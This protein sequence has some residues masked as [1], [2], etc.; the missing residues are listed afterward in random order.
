MDYR[1]CLVMG[2]AAAA[3]LLGVGS[4]GGTTAVQPADAEIGTN[5][6]GE[7]ELRAELFAELARIGVDPGK[8]A[9]SAP[10]GPGVGFYNVQIEQTES[11]IEPGD[12]ASVRMS[13][14]FRFPGDY[15]ANGEVNISDVTTLAQHLGETV[16]YL[17]LEDA[18]GYPWW[19]TQ[20]YREDELRRAYI[21]GDGNGEINS[22]DIIPIAQHFGQS[23]S[24]FYIYRRDPGSSEF[25]ELED[26][27]AR[28]PVPYPDS[29]Y[30]FDGAELQVE[31]L[32]TFRI[33]PW[34]GKTATA[35]VPLDFDLQ[36]NR[37]SVASFTVT[38]DS[39]TVPATLTL[40]ASASTDPDG[41]DFNYYYKYSYPGEEE[42]NPLKQTSNAIE[43]LTFTRAG[44]IRITLDLHEG[45]A[46]AHAEQTINLGMAG[47]RSSGWAFEEP[48]AG[49][50]SAGAS[51]IVELNGEP[52]IAWISSDAGPNFVFRSGGQ[53]SE[54]VTVSGRT[55]GQWG[56]VLDLRIIAARPALA[57]HRIFLPGSSEVIV[58]EDDTYLA[59]S[60]GHDFS[61]TMGAALVDLAGAPA[62]LLKGMPGKT[63]L[64]GAAGDD[65]WIQLSQ[66]NELNDN[67]Y[68]ETLEV[69]GRAMV[70]QYDNTWQTSR[71]SA[72]GRTWEAGVRLPDPD[73]GYYG[74]VSADINGRLATVYREQET[75]WYRSAV[76]PVASAWN[77]PVMLF[78][79]DGATRSLLPGTVCLADVAGIPVIARRAESGGVL[80]YRAL[81]ADGSTWGPAEPV[82]SLG[83]TGY[84]LS[85]AEIGGR[86]A[87]AYSNSSSSRLQYAVE[88][89]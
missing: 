79:S 27:D 33:V 62:V 24:G 58:A 38:A 5:A 60:D 50:S 40:D 77:D 13:W 32:T 84:G 81:D 49:R 57:V 85:L 73:I 9:A 12:P 51:D 19:P 20:V 87:L 70:L 61:W 2:I 42:D 54:Y 36:S 11:T 1:A 48:L 72:D 63:V 34:N 17:P 47:E 80:I 88:L 7:A 46:G 3:A 4:C 43:T 53:W 6:V 35:G 21:D 65:E 44:E 52:A 39:T 71:A 69:G 31:G 10:S 76:D 26:P 83:N 82:D 30:G 15:D 56:A 28:G 59:W 86:A 23:L 74:I 75:L 66:L 16:E 67:A 8:A 45:P 41:S 68:A 64:M 37:P 29:W 78:A 55:S 18:E 89:P 14:R 22:A 25:I